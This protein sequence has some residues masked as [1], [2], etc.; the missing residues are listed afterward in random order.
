MNAFGMAQGGRREDIRFLTGHGRYV[1]DIAP[2]DALHAVFLRSPVAHGR[3]A[4]L[5]T[6]PALAI[7]GVRAVLT[8][9]DL[10]AAGIKP[11]MKGATVAGGAAPERPVLAR[12]VVRFV[13][14]PIACVIADTLAA[15]K[16]GAEAIGLDL[17]EYPVKLDLAAGGPVVHPVAPDNVAY[18]Y[19][20]GNAESVDAA[21]A[22]AAHV[23]RVR[24]EDNRI[25]VASMEPRGAYAEWQDG[26]LHL[27]FNGQGVWN[28]KAQMAAQF[29]LA[30]DAVRVTIPDVGGGFG[31]KAMAYPEYVVIAQ[32]AR[33][34]GA[35]VRWMS[36]RTEA[37]L[38]DNAGRDLVSDVVL[39]FDA[40]LKIIGYRVKTLSNLGAYN[41]Q[42]GQPIQ[43]ELF[44]KVLTGLYDIQAAHL[45][46]HGIY[47]NT[48]Q[49]DAYRGAGRPEAICALE[50]AMDHAARVLGVDRFDLRRRSFIRDFPYRTASG[51]LYDVG[52]FPRVL[53]R[54]QHD[55]DVAGFAV[56]RAE[57]ET[58]GLLR[59]MGLS[60][61]I[62]AILGAPEETAQVD[63]DADGSVTLR[64]GTQSNGQ[65]HET[66]Y[67]RYLSAQTGIPEDSIRILQGDSDAIPTGGGTGGS[68]SVT[69]QTNATRAT[70]DRMVAD[71]AAFLASEMGGV[72]GFDDGA[73]R[74]PGTNRVVT[75]LEAA[76]LARAA[77]RLDLLCHR[78]SAT[79]PG[80]SYP[81]G[82]HLAEVEV[83]PET[84]AVRLDRYTIVDDFGTLLAPDLVLGQ[85]HGG[86]VQGAGQVLGER[87]VH[88]E[89]GQLLTA[90]FMDYAMP[91]AGDMPIFRIAFAPVPSTA[92]SLGMKGCGEAG[93][94]G[95]MAAVANAVR[96]ALAARGIGW[97]DMPFTPA[98]VWAVLRDTRS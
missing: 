47:T 72:P 51:E 33:A 83:D 74:V 92:N 39:A 32:A 86:V 30:P 19:E 77:G 57:S 6:S 62:E 96:D 85:V 42:F 18:R 27:C 34:L 87:V 66:V 7:P 9:T 5:D 20:M 8:L 95:A 35:P 70:V 58:R 84:G 23:V 31:M 24:V 71:F 60:C 26:R 79:L 22:A 29:G 2:Q 55:A 69:V 54:L 81:N 78:H 82:A 91:R 3:I 64:V 25:I 76:A 73:F 16:D 94:V 43:S 63:F 28:Q 36:E 17:E 45:A 48:T 59:G 41:S 4:S 90:S 50:S 61:Y 11:G 98:R 89:T 15:A 49:V 80:R 67:A 97:A 13:G 21:I 68:R 37:M 10:E 88:D 40:G 46:V 14:E 65:G 38:T 12:E 53:D 93:T 52:D 75:M 44:S 56:R 1:D